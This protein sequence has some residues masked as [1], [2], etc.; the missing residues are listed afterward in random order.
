[1]HGLLQEFVKLAEEQISRL[2]IMD[3]KLD[4]QAKSSD[5][6]LTAVKSGFSFLTQIPSITIDMKVVLSLL[7]NQ[8]VAQQTTPR[9]LGGHWQ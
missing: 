7:R 8:I 2:K 1:M 3:E 5:M 4:L 9:F 6:I